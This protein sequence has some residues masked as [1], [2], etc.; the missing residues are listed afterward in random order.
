MVPPIAPSVVDCAQA[1][2]QPR[3]STN[4]NIAVWKNF[5]RNII[6][7]LERETQ[8]F[9]SAILQAPQFKPLL[10]I[11]QPQFAIDLAHRTPTRSEQQGLFLWLELRGM[12]R[13][14]PK[15]ILSST[16]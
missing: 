12:R 11:D 7:L 16:S 2:A 15:T 6:Q 13:L 5:V 9:N 1:A 8:I 14:S 3:A 4:S 10:H